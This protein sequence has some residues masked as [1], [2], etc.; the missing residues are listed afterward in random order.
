MVAIS[1]S[2]KLFRTKLSSSTLS[3]SW[4]MGNFHSWSKGIWL[5]IIFC[6]KQNL[7]RF[8]DCTLQSCAIDSRFL[9]KSVLKSCL[10]RSTKSR[11]HYKGKGKLFK[12]IGQILSVFNSKFFTN[13]SH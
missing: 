13:I 4:G 1:L 11:I 10:L 5:H 3:N 9:H 7:F 8:L 12:S 2:S 6:F